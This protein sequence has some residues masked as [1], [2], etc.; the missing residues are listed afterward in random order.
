MYYDNV[1]NFLMVIEDMGLFVFE[2]FDLEKVWSDK[3]FVKLEM[4]RVV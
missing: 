2:V 3:I 4:V 1:R